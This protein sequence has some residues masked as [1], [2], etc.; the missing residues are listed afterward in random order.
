MSRTRSAR[1]TIHSRASR[2]P[3]GSPTATPVPHR[4]A[5]CGAATR[6]P[7]RRGPRGTC[8]ARP[9]PDDCRSRC[10]SPRPAPTAARK[11]LARL[12]G[13]L[14]QRRRHQGAP[15]GQVLEIV[16]VCEV[17]QGG[18]EEVPDDLRVEDTPLRAN[19]GEG[20]RSRGLTAA[21]GSV[22]P[23]DHPPKL[24]GP[25]GRERRFD[26][27]E[28]SP[29]PRVDAGPRPRMP[30]RRVCMPRAG[31]TV[32]LCRH[33]SRP[34]C[35]VELRSTLAAVHAEAECRVTVRRRCRSGCRRTAGSKNALSTTR[36]CY[37]RATSRESANIR[38][39]LG[40]AVT[41]TVVR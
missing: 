31:S 22:E 14:V 21:E 28:E 25:V 24:L 17:R 32:A 20:S 7:G 37:H 6:L 30:M 10:S 4:I 29:V 16:D 12:H 2:Q 23:H 1:L 26:A 35:R 13:D 11:V 3:E 41:S 15:G 40:S 39:R 5:R 38:I 9:W 36:F 33:L 34:G 18:A 19:S 8:A 27:D